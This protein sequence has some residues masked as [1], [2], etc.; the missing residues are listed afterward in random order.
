LKALQI[1]EVLGPDGVLLVDVPEPKPKG[2]ELLIRV[3]AAGLS[4]PDLLQSKGMYQI[5]PDLPFIP[6]GELCGVVVRAPHDSEFVA[7]DAVVAI[8]NA[9][10]AELAVAQPAATFHLPK[11]MSFV[12]GAALLTNY[13][14]AIFGLKCR[15][16][17]AAGE[18]VLV[19]GA[20]GG[21]GTAAIQVARALNASKIIG[22]V[23]SEVK[24]DAALKA[25]A[26][27]TV[28]STSDWKREVLALTA[29]QGVDL[30]YDPVGGDAFSDA[31]RCL[32]IFGR[33]VVIGFASGVIPE[34][35]TNRILL[36]NIDVIG[37]VLGIALQED[38][39]LQTLLHSE[40]ERMVELGQVR[41]IVGQVVP[42]ERAAD[43]YRLL[44]D[45]QAVGKVVIEIGST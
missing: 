5:K 9:A 1:A 28:Y 36:R 43:G 20:G 32:R 7:G 18:S 25:G 3:E 35:K 21:V 38:P 42:L 23:S 30:A 6:G 34:V 27:H 15:G 22:L 12:D 19:L 37:S 2:S 16:R 33:L 14:T 26:D 41:P 39:G 11:G 13:H 45:R 24:S 4:F 29:G 8:S 44:E 17:L 40:L 10:C 31:M